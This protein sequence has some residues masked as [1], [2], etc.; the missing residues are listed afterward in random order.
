MSIVVAIV[1]LCVV[2]ILHEAGHYFAA[3]WTGMKV[4]RFS[5]F[6]IGPAIVKL[7]TWRGTEFVIG[8][9]PFGAYVLIRGMEPE[10][11]DDTP[12]V[13]ADDLDDDAWAKARAASRAEAASVNFRD[14]PLWARAAVLAGGP[15]ANYLVAM[16]LFLAVYMLSGVR[17]TVD[18]IEIT[19]VNEGKP[20]A[21]AGLE[22]GDRLTKSATR[23]STRPRAP[24][25]RSISS[26]PTRGSRSTSRSSATGRR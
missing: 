25:L 3:I 11:E 26:W 12:V 16:I 24:K 9:I 18:R 21:T 22:V 5:V 15:L 13:D 7:G 14:K 4:D 6:G 2:I 1:A 10:P 23:P 17:G 8:A 19:Q 20:A